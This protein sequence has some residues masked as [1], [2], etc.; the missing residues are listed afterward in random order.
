MRRRYCLK[1]D[2]DSV[3]YYCHSFSSRVPINQFLLGENWENDE[4]EKTNKEIWLQAALIP[5]SKN[6]V[7]EG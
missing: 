7:A 4:I 1:S 3:N 5:G 2:I 6:T